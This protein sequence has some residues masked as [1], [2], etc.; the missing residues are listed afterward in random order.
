MGETL[1][2]VDKG[3]YLRVGAMGGGGGH[4]GPSLFLEI[5]DAHVVTYIWWI[6][7]S[8]QCKKKK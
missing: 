7:R 3:P 5:G 4:I 2:P 8:V 6:Y 1:G